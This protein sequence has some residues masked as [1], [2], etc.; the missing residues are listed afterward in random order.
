MEQPSIQPVDV[1]LQKLLDDFYGS[2]HKGLIDMT[3]QEA[4]DWEK[5][6]FQPD[7]SPVAVDSI[8]DHHVPVEGGSI[9]CRAYDPDSQTPLPILVYFHGGGW[10]LGD[11]ESAD[12][13]MRRLATAC[14]CVVLSVEYRLAPEFKFP[15]P[16]DDCLAAVRWAADH[17][18]ELGGTSGA[19]LAIGGDSAGGN[20]A[21]ACAIVFRDEG[22]PSLSCQYL[23][24]PVTDADFERGSMI[25]QGEGKL[26]ERSGMEWFWDHY[27]PDHAMRSDPLAC[28]IKAESLENL[29]PAL[30]TLAS[31]DPLYDEG[32]AYA[33]RLQDAS[34]PVQ[35]Q[36][37]PDLI[38]GYT[39]LVGVSDRCAEEV[40]C[41]QSI[42]RKM[43]HLQ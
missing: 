10:V 8:R 14:N 13:G 17:A 33:L 1:Q 4:R 21:A 34:V 20:L 27:C 25:E 9:C 19:P 26:L 2:G 28:P 35:V 30:I 31:H 6:L 15:I 41:I 29:P 3:P 32:L 37:A 16:V 42:L 40:D 5:E 36:I 38:H 24:Y 39:G 12:S 7:P 23:V 43:I 22:G 18:E 11:L